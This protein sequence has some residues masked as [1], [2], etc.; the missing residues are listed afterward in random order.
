MDKLF[1]VDAV[2]RPRGSEYVYGQHCV[3][4]CPREHFVPYGHLGFSQ[5]SSGSVKVPKDRVYVSDRQNS[6]DSS[7]TV[8]RRNTVKIHENCVACF[9]APGSMYRPNVRIGH[10]FFV[11]M[12]GSVVCMALIRA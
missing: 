1:R 11:Y 2:S 5:L 3:R 12:Q 6:K 4:F 10:I 8:T 7:C 9:M